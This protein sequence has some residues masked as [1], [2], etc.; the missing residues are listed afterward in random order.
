MTVLGLF[1][2]PPSSHL[3]SFRCTLFGS[4][5]LLLL[6]YHR[7]S[8]PVYVSVG[9]KTLSAAGLVVQWE[10][11]SEHGTLRGRPCLDSEL[12]CGGYHHSSSIGLLLPPA[13]APCTEQGRSFHYAA[14]QRQ[15]PSQEKN[16]R[17]Q[18]PHQRV[19]RA[20]ARACRQ[21]RYQKIAG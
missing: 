1:S 21:N 19:G 11:C 3:L 10:A 7:L 2:V 18:E 4:I 15:Q 16:L 8:M 20:A 17:Q 6:L 13:P 14:E 5:L 12:W 9:M